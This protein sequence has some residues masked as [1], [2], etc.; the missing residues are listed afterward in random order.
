M[1]FMELASQRFS[2]RSFSDKPVEQEKIDLVLKAA[3]LAPTAVNYQP[4]MIYQSANG[5]NGYHCRGHD[6]HGKGK[7]QNARTHPVNVAVCRFIG[8]M[9]EAVIGAFR[10]AEHLDNLNAADVFDRRV[11]QR[12]CRRNRAL[13]EL[14]ASRHHKHI[15]EQPQ[16]HGCQ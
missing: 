6:H 1:D 12:L 13:V 8:V 7:R 11:I 15:A 5:E 3:Q 16:R 14:R 10:L 9:H 4:Q 2:V